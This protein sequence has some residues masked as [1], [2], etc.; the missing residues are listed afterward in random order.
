M[1][2]GGGTFLTYNKVIP[3]SYINFVSATRASVNISDRGFA[4]IG[5]ELDWGPEDKIFVVENSNFQTETMKI[6]G[7]DYTHEKMKYLRDLFMK[8]QTVYMYRLNGG[9]TKASNAYATAK[10]SGTRGNDITIIVQTNIDDGTKKDVTT[11]L[12]T[13]KVD[14]QT[15]KTAAELK[16]NDYITF[17]KENS[18][19]LTSGTKLTGG[20]NLSS[21]TGEQH[22]KFLDLLESYS[23]NVIGC[24]SNNETIKKLYAQWTKRMREEVGIKFQC[25]VY[26]LASDYEGVINLKNKVL[27]AGAAENA[28]VFWLTGAEASCAV[29]A[30]LTNTKYDGEFNIDTKFTQSQLAAGIKAGQLLFHNNGGE[31]YILTDINSLTTTTVE[32][33][34]DFQS[35]Q[36]IRVL[37]QI[38]NDIALLFNKRHLG[39]TRNKESGREAL[40]KDIVAHHQ[41]LERIEALENFDPKAVTVEKGPT[42]K[43]VIVTDPVTP[44]A[45]ME[46]L[47]MTVVVS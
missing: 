24:S 6:F 21:V 31:P 29:N 22:Q 7:Y 16:D 32:K 25:V 40:W 36:V 18:L 38:G 23:F 8:A 11:V 41:E 43:S 37:D 47:Y 15:V 42:K 4:A 33:N 19:E 1:A 45:C 5:V 12:G 28:I 44:V 2:N 34:E 13:S 35:N 39:K 20:T 30:T 17:K 3:G 14:I 9:G 26:N 10:Y 46:I 27:D